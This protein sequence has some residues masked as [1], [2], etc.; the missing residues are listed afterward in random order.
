MQTLHERNADICFR[1]NMVAPVHLLIEQALNAGAPRLL[2]ADPGRPSFKNLCTL[3]AESA[4]THSLS[5][6]IEEPLIDWPG[7]RPIITGQ[8]LTAGDFTPPSS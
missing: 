6:Q 7:K 5:W 2:L 4:G 3:C 8:L 1:Q